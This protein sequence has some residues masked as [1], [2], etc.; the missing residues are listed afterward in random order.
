[1]A[2]PKLRPR[3]ANRFT[4]TP[5]RKRGNKRAQ[6]SEVKEVVVSGLRP[7]GP[8]LGSRGYRKEAPT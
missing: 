2:S 7:Q 3:N 4:L 5:S 6:K 8:G 1:M